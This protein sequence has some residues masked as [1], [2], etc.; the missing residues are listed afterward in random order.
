MLARVELG[1]SQVKRH[2]P[3]IVAGAVVLA[4]AGRTP[5]PVAGSPPESGPRA[6]RTDRP[7][8]A[9]CETPYRS[10]RP[11]VDTATAVY[12]GDT[13]ARPTAGCNPTRIVDV[14]DCGTDERAGGYCTVRFDAT[15]WLATGERAVVV[16]AA[17]THVIAYEIPGARGGKKGRYAA[18][19]AGGGSV[20]LVFAVW[21]SSAN[22]TGTRSLLMIE[23]VESYPT[24]DDITSAALTPVGV[25]EI[26]FVPVPIVGDPLPL[27]DGPDDCN[28][29]GLPDAYEISQGVTPDRD[30]NG[31][32]DTCQAQRRQIDWVL[33][34]L[35]ALA[36]ALPLVRFARRRRAGNV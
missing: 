31:T 34:A 27:L 8:A 3:L 14:F 10:H 5:S 26:P 30:G 20:R 13:H 21:N 11:G 9:G 25:D 35:A 22:R 32:P 18:G 15:L 2:L 16:M 33:L 12:L 36:L 7:A 6:W 1:A 19:V 29:N 4:L 17:D 28:G 23:N 24:G